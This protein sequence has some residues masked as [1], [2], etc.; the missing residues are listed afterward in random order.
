MSWQEAAKPVTFKPAR[1]K[2]GESGAKDERLSWEVCPAVCE[3]GSNLLRE[4]YL[5][6]DGQGWQ[7]QK[8]AEAIVSA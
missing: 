7:A 6:S 2:S 1:G 3:E 8:S 4:D 5:T